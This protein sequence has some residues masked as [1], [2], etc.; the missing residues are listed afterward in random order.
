MKK[1]FSRVIR[2]GIVLCGFIAL[3]SLHN[4]RLKAIVKDSIKYIPRDY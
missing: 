2:Y 1:S 4:E 3:N